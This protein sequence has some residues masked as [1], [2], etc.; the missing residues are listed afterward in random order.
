[1]LSS[2]PPVW[3]L[4]AVPFLSW[5]PPI[6]PCLFPPE[7][8]NVR[9][10]LE[11]A[12]TSEILLSSSSEHF[13][14]S[15]HQWLMTHMIECRE[16]NP[17]VCLKNILTDKSANITLLL[18][19]GIQLWSKILHHSQHPCRELAITQLFDV[20][21]KLKFRNIR[22]SGIHLSIWI[23]C[24]T[25]VNLPQCQV[26]FF[27]NCPKHSNRIIIQSDTSIWSGKN[28]LNRTIPEFRPEPNTQIC[29][30]P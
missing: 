28:I 10:T 13:Y 29:L 11:K 12:K 20:W 23:L 15:Q 1:M 27:G 9:S 22:I 16:S 21:S 7:H 3:P 26:Q 8:P 19:T 24:Q 4:F 6:I 14:F 5:H 25:P 18:F 2:R 30:D 17:I